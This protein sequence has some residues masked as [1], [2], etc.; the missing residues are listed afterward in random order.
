MRSVLLCAFGGVL[1]GGA[2]S[3]RS[4]GA[5]KAAVVVAVL[6]TLA[7]LGGVAY[8]LPKGLLS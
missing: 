2:W 1:L 8:L 3:L 6:G 7:L 5:K 4:Q